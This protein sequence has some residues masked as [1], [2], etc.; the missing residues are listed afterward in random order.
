MSL[1]VDSDVNR[2]VDLCQES[3]LLRLELEEDWIV[4]RKEVS[5]CYLAV[6]PVELIVAVGR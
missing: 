5:V 2:Y 1:S 3:S 4:A 6:D